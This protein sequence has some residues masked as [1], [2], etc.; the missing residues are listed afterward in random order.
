MLAGDEMNDFGIVVSCG[1][2]YI[3]AA[4]CG[5][6]EGVDDTDGGSD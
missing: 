6:G 5:G 2:V 4:F 1:V 3:L